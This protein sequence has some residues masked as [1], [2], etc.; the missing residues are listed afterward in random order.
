MVKTREIK[1]VENYEWILTEFSLGDP[2]L[3]HKVYIIDYRE[4]TIKIILIDD[5]EINSSQE[6]LSL[7]I[8][9]MAYNIYV[10]SKKIDK[11]SALNQ[12]RRKLIPTLSGLIKSTDDYS[13]WLIS[14]DK[15]N[16]LSIL[17]NIYDNK[18]MG[19]TFLTSETK[20]LRP[21]EAMVLSNI[22]R[23]ENIIKFKDLH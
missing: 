11:S 19:Y 1:T 20:T 13:H 6:N 17:I 2:S 12:C 22:L 23:N 3:S 15:T 9:R 4:K 18:K 16:H 8:K 7:S 10:M 5:F 21:E 14:A